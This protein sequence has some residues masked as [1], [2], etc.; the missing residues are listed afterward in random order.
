MCFLL[1]PV[2]PV[3]KAGPAS[4]KSSLGS[5]Q[6]LLNIKVLPNKRRYSEGSAE[7]LISFFA[8]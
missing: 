8:S 3:H 4:P 6:K 1:L 7:A 2:T 5:C